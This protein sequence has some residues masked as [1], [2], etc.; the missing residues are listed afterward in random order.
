MR[1]FYAALK[2]NIN[3]HIKGLATVFVF[4]FHLSVMKVESMNIDKA[5]NYRINRLLWLCTI[6]N[7]KK[8]TVFKTC[9]G[10]D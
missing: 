10:T 2:I 9:K 3:K 4:N 6:N 8:N 1:P 5:I 7:L